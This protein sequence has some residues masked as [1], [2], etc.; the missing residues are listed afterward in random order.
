VWLVDPGAG[1]GR[2]WDLL[3]PAE[4]DEFARMLAPGA[5]RTRVAARAALR[6][7][8]GRRLGLPPAAVPLARTP[9]GK[10]VVPGWAGD[11]SVSHCDGLAAV[12]LAPVPVGVD[13][14]RRD[15]AALREAADAFLH[16]VERRALAGLDPAAAADR[17][18]LLWTGKEAVAKALGTGFAG[19]DPTEVALAPD[20]RPAVQRL[21]GTDPTRVRLRWYAPTA[22]HVLAVATIAPPG[23]GGGW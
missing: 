4:Q 22:S 11:C 3:T 15:P 8:L 6:L 20:A 19:L 12:A 13:V 1:H 10:L 2:G 21:P 9:A 18:A 14:E 16:P 5:R 7:V 17:L 23:A